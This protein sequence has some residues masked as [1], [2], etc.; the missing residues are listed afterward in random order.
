MVKT[1]NDEKYQKGVEDGLR[2]DFLDDTVQ[3][4]CG[5][6]SIYDK[7]YRYGQDHRSDRKKDHSSSDFGF[8]FGGQKD[9]S[10]SLSSSTS[11]YSGSSSCYSGSDSNSSAPFG[12]IICVFFLVGFFVFFGIVIPSINTTLNYASPNP[13]LSTIGSYGRGGYG[14]FYSPTS[15]A[16]D[17]SGDI[18][19][20]DLGNNVIQKLSPDGKFLAQWEVLEGASYGHALSIDPAGNLI[21]MNHWD[22]QRAEFKK[23]SPTG[24]LLSSWKIK[25][26]ASDMTSDTNGNIYS[27]HN[28]LRQ[29]KKL[30]YTYDVSYYNQITIHSPDGTEKLHWTVDSGFSRIAVDSKNNVIYVFE[31]SPDTIKKFTTDGK[32]LGKW[33]PSGPEIGSIYHVIDIATDTNGNLYVLEGNPGRVKK[34]SSTG[35]LSGVWQS[36]KTSRQTF[37]GPISIETDMMGNIYV[38][39]QDRNC[40]HKL[41]QQLPLP[42]K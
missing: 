37:D 21:M 17:S 27:I 26:G 42:K 31:K 9:E 34:F 8:T 40:I 20:D 5:G 38:V 30:K 7:G 24:E 13:Y 22:I 39:D 19:I 11:S 14:N 12:L 1:E 23:Y 32:S 10:S 3:N 33:I 41:S 28:H 16:V 15:V 6:G 36:G 2:G 35:T 29:L 18:Y 4:M 25:E